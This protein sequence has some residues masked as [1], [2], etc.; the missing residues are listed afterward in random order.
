MIL[1]AA[2]LA[3][4]FTPLF[5]CVLAAS[6]IGLRRLRADRIEAPQFEPVVPRLDDPPTATALP[7]PSPPPVDVSALPEIRRRLQPKLIVSQARAA[8]ILIEFM[9]S[10]DQHG[11]YTSREIDEWWAFAAAARDIEHINGAIVREALES[12]G[13]R[14]GQRRLNAPEFLIVRQRSGQVRPVLYRIP[15]CRTSTGELPDDPGQNRKVRKQSGDNPAGKSTPV[16]SDSQR[17]AA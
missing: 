3:A 15:K 17:V 10:E 2:T 16:Q 1:E 9:N 14:M 8:E 12:R 4:P 6:I 11:Y 7:K 13:L 5:G